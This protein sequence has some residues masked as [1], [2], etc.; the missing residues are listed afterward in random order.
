MAKPPPRTDGESAKAAML[1]IAGN[2]T[3]RDQW[4]DYDERYVT[5]RILR[6]IREAKGA[7]AL[8]FFL[9]PFAVHA[10]NFTYKGV[11]VHQGTATKCIGPE[12]HAPPCLPEDVLHLIPIDRDDPFDAMRD[13]YRNVTNA[14]GTWAEYDMR[15]VLERILRAIREAKAQ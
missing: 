12:V 8:A 1:G 3:G 5:Q 14:R 13:I 7:A 2:V 6:A 9:I 4:K 11:I 15:Y 10:Q